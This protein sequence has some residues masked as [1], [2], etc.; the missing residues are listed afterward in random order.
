M[1]LDNTRIG[2][3]KHCPR[4]YY[5][6]HVRHWAPEDSGSPALWFGVFWGAAMDKLWVH[7]TVEAGMEGFMEAWYAH[8]LTWPLPLAYQKQWGH[9]TP[10]TAKRMLKPYWEKRRAFIESVQLLHVDKGLS[11]HEDGGDLDITYVA[12]PDK[13]FRVDGEVCAVDHKSTGY[14][15]AA[16]FSFSWVEN[17]QLSAQLDGYRW[18]LAKLYKQDM[19]NLWVDAA[20][21]NKT[22]VKFELLPIRKMEAWNEEWLKDTEYWTHRIVE[23]HCLMDF[24]KNDKSCRA[25]NR[26]CEYFDICRWHPKPEEV[27]LP[28]GF[29]ERKWEPLA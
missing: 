12:K 4:Y 15:S 23:A 17:W 9:H 1:E 10:E 7:K 29:V 27:E 26:L 6:R 11:Y 24:R 3:F 18:L 5:Y 16:G 25:F 28:Q 14:G 19:V 22:A 2:D 21:V 20:L 13:V 8:G